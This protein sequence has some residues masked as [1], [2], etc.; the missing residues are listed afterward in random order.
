MGDIKTSDLLLWGGVAIAAYLIWQAVSG[1]GS[2]VASAV[3][4][5]VNTAAGGIANLWVSLTAAP[6]MNVLGNSQLPN[7][8]LVPTSSLTLRTDAS[9]NVYTNIAGVTYQMQ[10]WVT[11]ANGQ[12]VYPLVAVGT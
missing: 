2:A 4:S 9:G 12:P 1:A 5:G 11:G 10:P 8:A 3:S 7:G 6:S